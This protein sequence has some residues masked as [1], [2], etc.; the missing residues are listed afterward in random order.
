MICHPH[1]QRLYGARIA[2]GGQSWKTVCKE[3][4]RGMVFIQPDIG[5]VQE[6]KGEK[7]DLI[8][9]QQVIDAI[10]KHIDGYLYCQEERLV[11]LNIAQTIIE[12]WPSA[13][14]EQRWIPVSERLPEKDGYYLT[15]TMY[16]QVYCDH[17]NGIYWDRTETVIA[18]MPLPSP[19]KGER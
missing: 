9:R 18:W 3:D 15:T 7:M 10:Q 6:Q 8:D 12:K 14:P 1:S 5:I 16:K 17:W 2:I 19:Y 4:A 13:Q 11:G